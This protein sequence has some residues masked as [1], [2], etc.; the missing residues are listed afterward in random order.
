MHVMAHRSIVDREIFR[1]LVKF[2]GEQ[3]R[4]IHTSCHSDRRWNVSPSFSGCSSNSTDR[5][6]LGYLRISIYQLIFRIAVRGLRRGRND[7]AGVCPGEVT[8]VLLANSLSHTSQRCRNSRWCT[9]SCV[10]P[11]NIVLLGSSLLAS[12]YDTSRATFVGTTMINIKL[13]TLLSSQKV[14]QIWANSDDWSH[15]QLVFRAFRS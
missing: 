15:D 14:F 12:N 7:L 11:W 3:I 13:A 4:I 9:C 2:L 1:S 5:C 6:Q 8:R 10:S